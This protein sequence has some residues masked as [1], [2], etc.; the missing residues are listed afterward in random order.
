[1]G[2]VFGFP[3][4]NTILIAV[5]CAQFQKLKAAILDIRQQHITPHHVQENKQVHK[6]GKCNLQGNLNACIR[7]HQEIM[8]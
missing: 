3:C 4:L 8:E 7:L 5:I 1:M 6:I 2:L